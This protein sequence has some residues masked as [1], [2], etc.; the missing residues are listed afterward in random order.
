MGSTSHPTARADRIVSLDVIRGVAILGILPMNALTW[1]FDDLSAYSNL[2]A[3]GT[4]Q[5]VDWVVGIG[6]KVF[7]E[8]KMMALFSLLFGVGVVIF[9]ERARTKTTHPNW[10]SLWRFTLLLVIGIIHAAFWIGDVLVVYALCA[11]VVLAVQRRSP[12]TLMSCGVALV[13]AGTLAAGVV[14]AVVNNGDGVLGEYWVAGGGTMGDEVGAWFIADGFLRA[15]GMML[16]GVSLYRR[17]VVQGGLPRSVYQRMV[18]WGF[19]IGVPVSAIGVVV[20]IVDDWSS[21]TALVGHIP[22]GLG[23]IPMAFGYLGLIIL[24]GHKHSRVSSRLQAAGRMAMTNYLSQTVLGLAT[25]AVIADNTAVS[26]TGVMAWVCGVWVVQLWWST[27]WLQRYRFGPA[28]WLW[29]C[30]TYRQMHAFR[31]SDR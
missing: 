3:G 17:E 16:I 4:S 2:G 12:R 24:W 1:A 22:V 31:R 13:L 6:S 8:Q 19:G 14:Q 29:R 23:T 30:G 27:W 10:L 26:R 11:P 20:H 7:V 21:E 18:R 28:E 15:L 25:L 9:Y 5:P